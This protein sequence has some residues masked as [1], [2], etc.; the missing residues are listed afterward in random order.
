MRDE[1]RL[2]PGPVKTVLPVRLTQLSLIAE[3][4][5]DRT[6]FEW[7]I[8]TY[9]P[10]GQRLLSSAATASVNGSAAKQSIAILRHALA[11]LNR[12]EDA[13]RRPPA[14]IAGL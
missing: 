13:S 3:A 10:E 1:P 14:D 4:N 9:G 5:A 6:A 2:A 7:H 12:L 11:H 8:Y